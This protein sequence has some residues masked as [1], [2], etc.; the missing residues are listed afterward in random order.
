MIFYFLLGEGCSPFFH[1]NV[2]VASFLLTWSIFL[3]HLSVDGQKE[4]IFPLRNLQ[5][6]SL[7][8][9]I[10]L[11]TQN[12]KICVK[13]REIRPSVKQKMCCGQGPLPVRR[14]GAYLRCVRG[15]KAFCLVVSAEVLPP[16][17]RKLWTCSQ[18]KCEDFRI[19]G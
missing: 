7:R 18:L 14:F 10:F 15:C 13:I 3:R 11:G 19:C 17:L 6:I 16:P 2:F 1:A 9:T 8:K 12:Q 5:V 4:N